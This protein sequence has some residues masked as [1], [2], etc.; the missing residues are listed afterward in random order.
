MKRKKNN[1]MEKLYRTKLLN[2]S[3]TLSCI[4]TLGHILIAGTTVY[5]LTGANIWE[6]GIVAL[7]EPCLNGIWFYILHKVWM[8]YQ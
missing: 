2:N 1:S 7:V 8:H 6:A 4:Y 5:V 3:I